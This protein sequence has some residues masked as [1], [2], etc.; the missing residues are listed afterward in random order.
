ME[1]YCTML[2]TDGYLPGAQVLAHS[3]RDGGATRKLA[4]L[5]TQDFLSEATMKEL[6]RIYDYIIPVDRITN[7]S[8]G[9]LLMMDRLD[10]SSAFTK[11]HLWRMTQF[12][13]I[14]YIDADVVALR[15]PEELFETKEKFAAAPDIGWPDCFNSGVM[16]LKPDLGTYHGLLNLANRGIS[17]DGADQGLLNEYFRNWNRLSFVYNVTPSGHYQY[18]PAYNHYRSSITMA[19]FIGSNKPWAIGRHAGQ[20]NP[21]SAYGELL[22]RWWSIWDAHYRPVTEQDPALTWLSK[23]VGER[24]TI[25]EIERPNPMPTEYDPNFRREHTSFDE[26]KDEPVVWHPP[27][28][29]GPKQEGQRN[30]QEHQYQ[31]QNY[32][33]Q[34][35]QAPPPPQ[36][37]QQHYHHHHHHQESP[38]PP[39]FLP[40][41]HVPYVPRDL[42]YNAYSQTQGPP[43]S[44]SYHAQRQQQQH[45][46]PQIHAPRPVHPQWEEQGRRFSKEIPAR[47][48]NSLPLPPL[49]STTEE[50]QASEPKEKKSPSFEA[51]MQQWD[52]GR[53]SPPPNSRPE[54]SNWPTQLYENE[55]DQA[56][57]DTG[58][59]VPP[60]VA[61]P[62][63]DLLNFEVPPKPQPSPRPSPIFPWEH[64]NTTPATRVFAGEGSPS[65]TLPLAL[66][67]SVDDE[68][69]TEEAAGGY[70]ARG[71]AAWDS[72]SR[73]NAWDS[74]PSIERYV[75]SFQQ[76]TQPRR[77]VRKGDVTPNPQIRGADER[78]LRTDGE[79][80]DD[81][82]TTTTTITSTTGLLPPE[83]SVTP[84]PFKSLRGYRSHAMDDETKFPSAQGIPDQ[85]HWDPMKSLAE[86][87][88]APG[89]LLNRSPPSP[90]SLT[91]GSPRSPA[92]SVQQQQQLV[93]SSMPVPEKDFHITAYR[94]RHEMSVSSGNSSVT[95]SPVNTFSE[96]TYAS[97]STQTNVVELSDAGTQSDP[98]DIDAEMVMVGVH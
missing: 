32:Q 24:L 1:V 16:V 92:S 98:E 30:R 71:M 88:N 35:Y 90:Q 13:K 67:G 7:K 37:Q 84:T 54:A 15:A 56:K 61:S 27:P 45:Y 10:L 70:S 51:P 72:Y 2:L 44:Y 66:P 79:H 80:F 42:P 83:I 82:T 6:K 52:A 25:A 22:G 68:F 34:Q 40:K 28:V 93:S 49:P 38:P 23:G 19:H 58:L 75:A 76:S 57:Q 21:T 97:S 50:P 95:G 18:A 73:T 78:I 41:E 96:R 77:T 46:Q 11:I 31:P 29:G 43:P 55:W 81:E 89:E 94:K 5:V 14:V 85:Q 60:R 47:I 74:I 59:F 53:S 39:V 36:Q 91:R 63:T 12:E 4:I 64:G 3:L 9:N 20:E 8:H 65:P 62:P 48:E 33:P 17:F 26:R 87:R 86:L 69:E